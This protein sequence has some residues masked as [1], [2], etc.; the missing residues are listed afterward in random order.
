VSKYKHVMPVRAAVVE[1]DPFTRLTLV[2]ALNAHGVDVVYETGVASDALKNI[3]EAKPDVVV[4]DL[5]LGSGPTGID[6]AVE[7]RRQAP[8]LGVV[9]LTSFDDPRLL[10][11][12]LPTP[13]KG[14]QY[15]PKRSVATIATL[16]EAL[17][18]AIG[19]TGNPVPNYGRYTATPD[20][21]DVSPV[22]ELSDTQIDTLRLVARGF[23]NAEIAR[24]R[25][26]S[27]RAVEAVIAR[28][29]KILGVSNETSHNQRVHLAQV[30]FRSR[31]L[32]F[33]DDE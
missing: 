13:P 8:R 4:L 15:L 19:A 5:H 11:P 23:S 22:A 33:D 14:S 21:P 20:K 2:E 32:S 27:A 3:P 31:G 9:L 17:R 25:D 24:R 16:L 1:D 7:L 6:L 26:V 10:G 12:N 18:D 29:I 30:Y 28:L